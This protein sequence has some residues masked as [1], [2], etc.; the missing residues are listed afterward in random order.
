M[1]LLMSSQNPS[2][3]HPELHPNEVVEIGVVDAIN[4]YKVGE[5]LNPFA[6]IFIGNQDNWQ[7]GLKLSMESK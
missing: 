2:L 4:I 1:L 3:I 7:K 5:R 6:T